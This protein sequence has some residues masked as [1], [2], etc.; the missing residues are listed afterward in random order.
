MG[1]FFSA[2]NKVVIFFGR[3]NSAWKTSKQRQNANKQSIS[4]NTIMPQREKH[5]VKALFW[6]YLG[7]R[8][9]IK[10]ESWHGSS[11]IFMHPPINQAT[12]QVKTVPNTWD[13]QKYKMMNSSSGPCIQQ[14]CCT[15][16][17]TEQIMTYG[18]ETTRHYS[19]CSNSRFDW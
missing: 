9:H 5:I 7:D 14:L 11:L 17:K 12:S 8:F 19:N 18:L 10:L 13:L 16:H 15:P 4:G 2:A 3:S 1:I 6:F